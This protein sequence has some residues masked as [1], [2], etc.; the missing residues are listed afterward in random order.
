MA[1]SLG[2]IEPGIAARRGTGIRTS[3][4]V[5]IPARDYVEGLLSW[6]DHGCSLGPAYGPLGASGVRPGIHT[7]GVAFL[8]ILF[9]TVRDE[10]AG[11]I[12]P[13]PSRSSQKELP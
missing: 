8:V 13:L 2:I 3:C 11:A 4:R 1:R 10:C 12:A 7:L 5:V 9:P 6:S